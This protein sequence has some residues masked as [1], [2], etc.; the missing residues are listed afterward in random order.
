VLIIGIEGKIKELRSRLYVEKYR[1]Y[2]LINNVCWE[3]L[4][5]LKRE[6]GAALWGSVGVSSFN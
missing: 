1:V 3:A 2:V 5:K 4:K 6:S